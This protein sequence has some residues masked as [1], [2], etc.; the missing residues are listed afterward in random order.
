MKDNFQAILKLSHNSNT[1]ILDKVEHVAI[2]TNCHLS[3]INYPVV[4]LY[5]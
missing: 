4:L 1:L 5:N 2:A 3:F